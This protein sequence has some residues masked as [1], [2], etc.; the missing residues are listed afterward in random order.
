MS[1]TVSELQVVSFLNEVYSLIDPQNDDV[2]ELKRISTNHV[3]QQIIARTECM[4]N[5]SP[6]AFAKWCTKRGVN[7]INAPFMRKRERG[8]SHRVRELYVMKDEYLSNVSLV[9]FMKTTAMLLIIFF[10]F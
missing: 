7:F 3:Y 9:L 5:K 1:N 6:V 8:S 2:Y 4:D 10:S